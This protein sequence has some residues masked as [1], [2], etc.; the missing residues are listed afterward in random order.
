MLDMM[1]VLAEIKRLLKDETIVLEEEVQ[2]FS[3]ALYC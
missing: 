3:H 2:S 1:N